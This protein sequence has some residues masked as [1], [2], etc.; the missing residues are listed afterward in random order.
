MSLQ[1]INLSLQCFVALKPNLNKFKLNE[2]LL[3]LIDRELDISQKL[4]LWS[5]FTVIMCTIYNFHWQFSKFHEHY[6]IK[7][8]IKSNKFAV[9]MKYTTSYSLKTNHTTLISCIL[10]WVHPGIQPICSTSYVTEMRPILCPLSRPNWGALPRVFLTFQQE[11][12]HNQLIFDMFSIINQ[13]LYEICFPKI[14]NL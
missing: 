6:D 13:S 3:V 2:F 4:I 11:I 8:V 14:P 1:Y 7:H 12:S 10:W 5:W 9:S